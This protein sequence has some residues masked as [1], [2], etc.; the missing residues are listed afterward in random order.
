MTFE[1]RIYLLGLSLKEEMV[2]HAKKAANRP[3]TEYFN[4]HTY[5][6]QFSKKNYL[7]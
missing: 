6:T 5:F 4:R 3:G 2:R 7:T 1:V